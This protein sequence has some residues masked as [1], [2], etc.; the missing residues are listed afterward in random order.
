[1]NDTYIILIIIIIILVLSLSFILI[2]YFYNSYSNNKIVV[3]DNLVKTK[4][5]INNTTTTLKGIKCQT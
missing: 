5:Y 1:M 3:N 4:D 2:S